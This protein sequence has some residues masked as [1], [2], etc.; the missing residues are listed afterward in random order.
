[1]FT[2]SSLSSR[3]HTNSES[4]CIQAR[5]T[6]GST[7]LRKSVRFFVIN[8][9]LEIK[10]TFQVKIWPISCLNDSETQERGRQ[11]VKNPKRFLREPAPG[12]RQK[13]A[14]SALGQEIG[15]AAFLL[16]PRLASALKICVTKLGVSSSNSSQYIG[17]ELPEMSSDLFS[18]KLASSSAEQSTLF[19]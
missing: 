6:P 17:M 3:I 2:K 11:G 7:V 1:M 15:H 16:D 19:A 10:N 18:G 5:I 8:I 13:L 4:R 12:P 14:P 9:F